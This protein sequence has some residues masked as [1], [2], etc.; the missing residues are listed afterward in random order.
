MPDHARVSQSLAYVP[1]RPKQAHTRWTMFCRSVARRLSKIR[2]KP[3]LKAVAEGLRAAV[4][5]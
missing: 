1:L 3:L 4:S 2:C 5:L